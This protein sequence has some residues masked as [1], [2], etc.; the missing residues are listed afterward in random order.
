ML[1]VSKLL[2]LKHYNLHSKLVLILVQNLDQIQLL[3]L[4]LLQQ[5][6]IL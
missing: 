3:L 1:K 5:I 2:L 6:M 4:Q